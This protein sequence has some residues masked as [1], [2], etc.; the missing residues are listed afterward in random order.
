MA[1]GL[2]SKGVG[3]HA[4]LRQKASKLIE[5]RRFIGIRA[6]RH[7]FFTQNALG[8]NPGVLQDFP[9]ISKIY[10]KNSD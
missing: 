2:K 7:A 10:P 1:L 6:W 9:E 8:T 3:H 5:A 4:V